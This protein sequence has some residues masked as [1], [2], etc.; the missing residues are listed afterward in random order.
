[1]AG[2]IDV[3]RFTPTAGGTSNWTYS[4]AVTGYQSPTAAG[5]VDGKTYRYRAE[6]ADLT[7]WE[8]GYGVYTASTGVFARTTILFNSSGTTSAI[9]F[10]S[11][12]TVGIVLLA[13]DLRERLDANRTYYVATTG[14]DSNTGLATQTTGTVTFTNGSSNVGWTSHGRSVGDVIYFTTSGTLPTNFTSALPVYVKTVVDANTITVSATSGGSA[15]TAGS[16]GSGTHTATLLSPFLT[17]NAAINVACALDLSI[18]NVSIIV[19]GGTYTATCTLKSYIGVGPITLQGDTATPSNVVIST[20]STHAINASAGFIGSW[21][22]KGF[23]VQ[24][25]TSGNCVY[26]IGPGTKVS[27]SN[28]DFGA[29]A[30]T[31]LLVSDARARLNTSYTISGGAQNHIFLNEQAYLHSGNGITVTLTGTPAFSS[32]Y[33]TAGLASI[34]NAASMT[35]SGAATGTRFS[36]SGGC[37]ISTGGGGASYFPG[38][39][40]GSGDPGTFDQYT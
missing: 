9:N 22:I 32:T 34:Y 13:E 12:P 1:M 27:M 31:H 36:L 18:Y 35:F 20:T 29:C 19:A 23:K 8:V 30:G 33:L 11:A 5:A 14:S 28:M 17:V 4:S 26:I 25:T 10:S 15:I 24:T 38:N 40:A 21:K 16:A 6:S 7:Q 37:V 39:A 3:C 2:Q